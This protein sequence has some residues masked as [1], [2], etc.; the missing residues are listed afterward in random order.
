MSKG[1]SGLFRGTRGARQHF[2]YVRWLSKGANAYIA[3]FGANRTSGAAPHIAHSNQPSEYIQGLLDFGKAEKN[4]PEPGSIEDLRNKVIAYAEQEVEK[5]EKIS[6][7]KRNK[8]N[9]ATVVYDAS[10]VNYYY[11]RNN[12]IEIDNENNNDEENKN[13][14]KNVILFGDSEHDGLLPKKSLNKLIIGN[15]AEIHAV[16]KALNDSAQLEN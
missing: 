3:G 8:F 4:E 12:G 15:C 6:N 14:T 2:D 10:N 13:T 16:N 1:N 9:T 11:G 5:L 7:G